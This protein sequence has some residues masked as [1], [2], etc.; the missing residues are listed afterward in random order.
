MTTA[1][2]KSLV[3]VIWNDFLIKLINLKV[4][5]IRDKYVIKNMYTYYINKERCSELYNTTSYY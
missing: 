1:F 4:D 3:I 5:K 2:I